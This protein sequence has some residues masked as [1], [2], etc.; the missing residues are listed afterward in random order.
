MDQSDSEIVPIEPERS[1]RR[2]NS[3]RLYTRWA[4]SNRCRLMGLGGCRFGFGGGIY[5][6]EW[7]AEKG[8]ASLQGEGMRGDRGLHMVFTNRFKDAE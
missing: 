4:G 5:E 3:I 1:E 2:P 6:P 8:R 7:E